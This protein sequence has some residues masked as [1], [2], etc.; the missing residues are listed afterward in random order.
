MRIIPNKKMRALKNLNKKWL[1]IKTSLFKSF[2]IKTK[3]E[4]V[5]V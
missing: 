4:K 1:I 3:I 5:T 2:K